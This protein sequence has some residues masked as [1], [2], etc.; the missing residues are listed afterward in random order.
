LARKTVIPGLGR[1]HEHLF[2]PAPEGGKDGLPFSI[3][4]IDSGPRLYLRAASP[5]REPLGSM[6]PY[7]ILSSRTDRQGEKPGPTAHHGTLY[8][9]LFGILPQFHTLADAEDAGPHVDYGRRRRDLVQGLHGHHPE[10][11][12][13]GGACSCAGIKSYRHLCAV[14]FREAAAL[15][16]DNLE[17]GI[18]VDTEFLPGK[19]PGICL[20]GGGRIEVNSISQ[21]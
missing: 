6:E 9:D 7:T 1:H 11:E 15:G 3:E 19:K 2:L 20:W 10:S 4:M 12:D 14:G 5:R 16:I 13:G 17:H 8:R 18:I 21:T